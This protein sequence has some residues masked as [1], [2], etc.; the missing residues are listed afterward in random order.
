MAACAHS[1]F[2]T[3]Q[4]SEVAAAIGKTV[5]PTIIE[6]WSV[7]DYSNYLRTRGLRDAGNMAALNRIIDALERVGFLLPCGPAPNLPHFMAQRYMTQGGA[8]PGQVGGNLWLSE[9]FGAELIIPSY[10]VVTVQIAGTDV[11]GK[12]CWGTGLVLDHTHVVTNKHVVAAMAPGASP[13]ITPPSGE[14]GGESVDCELVVHPH[15]ELDVALVEIRAP[16]GRGLPRLAGMAFRDPAWAD[17]VFLFGYPHVPMIAGMAVTVQRGEVVNPTL[18]TP[19]GGGLPRQKTFLYSAIARPGNSG[20][21]IVAHDGRVIGLVVE[22]SSPTT[23]ASAADY[24]PPPPATP[25][26]RIDHLEREVEELTAK[27]RAPS[28]Y[29][30]IP[31]SEIIRALSD[32][33]FGGLASIDGP[34]P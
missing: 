2:K 31:S 24:E 20:G 19:A 30:G 11:A 34:Q 28:F 25:E 13:S 12:P 18:E 15:R 4:T 27:V 26:G 3:P 1:F 29:R 32:L 9:I 17:E 8:S 6:P 7:A 14:E 21:P 5:D 22:D 10:N 33:G 23:R 16:E